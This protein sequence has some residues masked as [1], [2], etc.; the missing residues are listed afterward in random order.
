MWKGPG[1][2]ECPDHPRYTGTDLTRLN[3]IAPLLLKGRWK[4]GNDPVDLVDDG[5]TLRRRRN[6]SIILRRDV[7]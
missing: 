3:R 2:G 7:I 1:R 4:R 6:L 5:A